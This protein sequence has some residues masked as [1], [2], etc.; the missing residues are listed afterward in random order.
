MTDKLFTSPRG[1]VAALILAQA[2]PHW[3]LMMLRGVAGIAFGAIAMAMPGPTLVSLAVLFA[4]Y[5]L[6]DGV[7]AIAAAFHAAREH[8]SWIWFALGGAVDIV[9]AV[10]A[11]AWPA[12]TIAA[13][14]AI[15][16]A[17]ALISGVF[18]IIAAFRAAAHDGR[19]LLGLGGAVS[20]A[21]GVLL[22]VWPVAGALTM[23]LWLGAYTLVFGITLVVL[24]F[25][26][27][28]A[29]KAAE[30]HSRTATA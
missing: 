26:L 5:M 1:A 3:G 30:G 28:S 2:R 18:M 24:A 23:V 12:V 14:V 20:V 7:F 4:A 9:V 21:W 25:K 15:A 22:L 16:A 29:E 19:W 11:L 13:F 10:I 6:V 8:Q 17:W 27:R